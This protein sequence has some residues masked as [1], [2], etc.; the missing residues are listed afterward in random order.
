MR[1]LLWLVYPA[2]RQP[3]ML[4]QVFAHAIKKQRVGGNLIGSNKDAHKKTRTKHQR[5]LLL[6]L[7]LNLKSANETVCH[8]CT[9]KYKKNR[10]CGRFSISLIYADYFFTAVLSALALAPDFSAAYSS[11]RPLITSLV[12][13]SASPANRT[14]L[15][16]SY[17]NTTCNPFSV[18][19]FFT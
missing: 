2:H 7:G 8:K 3:G 11:L 9:N 14:S 1:K 13:S 10:R 15:L 5:D 4:F 17:F 19:Y 16:T 18:P 12:M 6:F